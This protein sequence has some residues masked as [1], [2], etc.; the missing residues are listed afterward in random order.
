MDY[1][2]YYLWSAAEVIKTE[3]ESP[4]IINLE[5]E[6]NDS[7]MLS[8]DLKTNA[9]SENTIVLSFLDIEI[10]QRFT[11]FFK[12]RD[13]ST[14]YKTLNKMKIIDDYIERF[15][16]V[17][18]EFTDCSIKLGITVMRETLNMAIKKKIFKEE[19]FKILENEFFKN[20]GKEAHKN[21]R[22]I[23]FSL[24]KD[25]EMKKILLT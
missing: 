21:L 23:L 10:V 5:E 11:T 2:I 12:L 13:S 14:K 15:K 16:E 22:C 24:A 7:N 1:Y 19:S 25:G 6:G 20:P 9:E 18:K 8:F 3:E 4:Y 17:P